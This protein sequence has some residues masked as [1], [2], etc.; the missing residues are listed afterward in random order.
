MIEVPGVFDDCMRIVE[1]LAERYQVCLLNSKNPIRI[2][3]QKSYAY[4]VAQ[5]LGYDT[6]TS[7]LWCPSAMPAM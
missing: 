3:G 6:A 7:R 5:Q 1:Q 2:M 4:E